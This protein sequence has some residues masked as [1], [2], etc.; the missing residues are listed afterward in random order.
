[1]VEDESEGE[2]EVEACKAEPSE[3][4]FFL[5]VEWM[6]RYWHWQ[7]DREPCVFLQYFEFHKQ[8]D[9]KMETNLR[10]ITSYFANQK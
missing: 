5:N 2:F 6:G 7:D 1:M 8:G 9:M 10:I 4:F 3:C